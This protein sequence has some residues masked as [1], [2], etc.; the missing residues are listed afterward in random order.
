MTRIKRIWGS[1]LSNAV[2]RKE[3]AAGSFAR[4]M[5]YTTDRCPIP[6]PYAR[7]SF[8]LHIFFESGKSRSAIL[9]IL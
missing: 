4:R 8:G 2:S 7:Q 1:R 9:L 3:Q 5:Q 6:S